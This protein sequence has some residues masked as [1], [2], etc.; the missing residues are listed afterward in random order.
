MAVLMVS[1]DVENERATSLKMGLSASPLEPTTLTA[2]INAGT[3]E[4]VRVL[5][6]LRFCMPRILLE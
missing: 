6:L 2:N 5:Q 1:A 4:G 3:E